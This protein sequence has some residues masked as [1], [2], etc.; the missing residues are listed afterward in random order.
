M[1]TFSNFDWFIYTLGWLT[2]WYLVFKVL[3]L[4]FTKD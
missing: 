4:L 1:D 2:F 3:V